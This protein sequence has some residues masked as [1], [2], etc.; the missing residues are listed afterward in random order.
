MA[1]T[2]F[3]VSSR[4]KLLRLAE[5]ASYDREAVYDIVDAA[6]VC[7]VGHAIDGQPPVLPTLIP[8]DGD[9]LLLHG[10]GTNRTLHHA[11]AGH[12]I[13]VEVTHVDGIVLARSISIT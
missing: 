9:N 13:C 10:H 11:G 8:R 1:V 6:L 4:T 7:H 12:T 2:S 3:D 5:R